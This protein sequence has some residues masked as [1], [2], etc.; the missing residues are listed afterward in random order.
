[1][2]ISVNKIVAKVGIGQAKP[3]G[4]I[5]IDKGTEKQLLRPLAVR[6]SLA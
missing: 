1:M 2:G 4:F 6:R 3:N 5:S